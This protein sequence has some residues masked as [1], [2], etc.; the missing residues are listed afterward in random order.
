MYVYMYVLFLCYD[1]ALIIHF[2]AII[3][4]YIF[5]FVPNVC[6]YVCT[7]IQTYIRGH[8]RH[9]ARQTVSS[10][11]ID[12]LQFQSTYIHISIYIYKNI[13]ISMYI[14]MQSCVYVCL[15]ATCHIA[16]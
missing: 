4:T 3:L 5:L 12:P 10:R 14:V 7:Y 16:M 11:Y 9:A 15:L 8:D 2:R 13:Y 6:T 1:F